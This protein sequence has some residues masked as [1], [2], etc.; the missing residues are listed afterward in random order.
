MGL[1]DIARNTAVN[2]AIAAA[3]PA[4]EKACAR[5]LVLDDITY[6]GKEFALSGALLGGEN[7]TVTVGGIT[8]AEDC[9]SITIGTASCSI[10]GLENLLS[11]FVVGNVFPIPERHRDKAKMA[12]QLLYATH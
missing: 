8:I 7:V 2:A 5:Y 4:V 9:S 12:K 3:R 6:N 1:M 10:P 11:D